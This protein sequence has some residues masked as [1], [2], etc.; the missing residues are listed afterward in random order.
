MQMIA[1][2]WFFSK[3]PS[4]T[5]I[6]SGGRT[7]LNAKL[8][9]ECR[10]DRKV[11]VLARGDLRSNYDRS[12]PFSSFSEIKHLDSRKKWRE[13]SPL[14]EVAHTRRVRDGK[15]KTDESHQRAIKR[16]PNSSVTPMRHCHAGRGLLRESVTACDGEETCDKGCATKAANG[17][18]PATCEHD[19]L[20][21]STTCYLRAQPATC[22]PRPATCYRPPLSEARAKLRPQAIASHPLPSIASH[23][24]LQP[25]PLTP[26]PPRTQSVHS[27]SP[28]ELYS[29]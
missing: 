17:P 29:T 25:A 18:R 16:E 9:K 26:C 20:P 22:Y 7:R 15:A 3:K 8:G 23:S 28:I 14:C 4:R 11:W 13:I 24:Q 1:S 21:A 6:S 10:G 19:L 5:V 12:T 2:C 27:P